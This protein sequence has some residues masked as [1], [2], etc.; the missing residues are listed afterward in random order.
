MTGERAEICTALVAAL[1]GQPADLSRFAPQAVQL[2]CRIHGVGPLLHHQLA[3]DSAAPDELR[4]WLAQQ[5]EF[6]TQR[7]ARMQTEL[8]QILAAFAA[9][10]VP[11]MP[12][13]GAILAAR[14]YPDPGLRPM[15]DLD[16]L[17]HPVNFEAATRLLIQLGYAKTTAHRKHTE[18]VRPENRRVVSAE[19]EHPDNPRTVELHPACRESFGGPALDLTTLMWRHASPGQ[20][21]GQPAHLPSAA[22]LWMH[23]LVHAGYHI[24]QGRGRLLH[25]VDLARLSAHASPPANLLNQT[26]ARFALPA[27]DLLHRTFPQTLE[28]ALVAEQKKRAPARFAQ[29]AATRNLV[30]SSLLNPKPAGPYLGRALRFAA[31]HP[32]DVARALRAAFLPRLDELSLDHPRLARSPAPWLAYFLLPLDWLKR[33]RRR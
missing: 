9:Q 31:G 16:V 22:A 32:P 30:N 7:V 27:L 11:L 23:G 3:G 5:A 12:L 33:L 21:L 1:N 18:F 8:A 15:A 4:N 20:L 14:V 29:W 26:D 17:V 2:A 19:F 13:K 24:W 28:P 6:N 25:L 10:N